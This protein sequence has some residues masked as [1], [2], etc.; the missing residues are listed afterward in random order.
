MAPPER[1]GAAPS[2]AGK[3]TRSKSRDA[4]KATVVIH[5]DDTPIDEKTAP[6]SDPE[7]LDE[8]QTATD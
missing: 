2:I 8:R 7:Q 6:D 5:I 1:G 4:E 3:Q